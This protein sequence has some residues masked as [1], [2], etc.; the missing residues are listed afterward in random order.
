MEL[1]RKGKLIAVPAVEP[2]TAMG[3]RVNE[4]VLAA[5]AVV[6]VLPVVVTVTTFWPYCGPTFRLQSGVLQVAVMIAVPEAPAVTVA[7]TAPLAPV[8]LELPIG[9]EDQV[10]RGVMETPFVSRISAVRDC[11]P[12]GDRVNDVFELL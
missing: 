3:I 12:A 1:G 10:T 7:V 5:Y 2:G 11:V 4:R 6:A 9:D 8:T